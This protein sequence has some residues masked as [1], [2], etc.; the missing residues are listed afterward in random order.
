MRD[1]GRRRRAPA[2]ALDRRSRPVRK[3]ACSGCRACAGGKAELAATFP[4]P[5]ADTAPRDGPDFQGKLT[6]KDFKVLNQPFVTRL[7]AAGSLDGLVNLM[8]NQGIAAD[9]V[10]V[11]FSLEER[12]SSTSTA[13]ARPDPRSGSTAD[14]WIDRP[15]NAIAL[16]GTLVPVFGINNFL[17]NIPLVGQCWSASRARACSG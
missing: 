17:S 11:P 10:E 8:Q 14:G 12:P 9:K 2:H 13:R 5:A 16:K 7:F 1:D 4:G 3:G 15:K 6:L